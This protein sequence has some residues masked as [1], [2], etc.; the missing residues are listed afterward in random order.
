M[1]T[2][3]LFAC[4]LFL[5]L[6]ESCKKD[7]PGPPLQSSQEPL[8]KERAAVP[9]T[10][11][12]YNASVIEGRLAFKTKED[13][14]SLVTDPT[15]EKEAAFINWVDN[16]PDFVSHYRHHIDNRISDPIRDDFFGSILNQ[17]DI[18]QIG[19]HIFK[20]DMGKEKVFALGVVFESQLQYL[21]QENITNLK[22]K[23]FSTQEDVLEAIQLERWSIFCTEPYLPLQQHSKPFHATNVE[24][25]HLV[26]GIY[27]SLVSFIP[28]GSVNIYNFDAS[29]VYYKIRC[30]NTSGPYQIW[31]SMGN[32][33]FLSGGQKLTIYRGIHNFSKLH[34]TVRGRDN[35][36]NPVF[37]S[38]WVELR[39]NA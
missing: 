39:I 36:T 23:T 9:T 22:I 6:S 29:F 24:A 1:K 17:D 16:L 14:E 28:T 31:N 38:D 32:Y 5:G 20:V 10:T 37:T 25:N 12:E 21:L 18:V 7:L 11:N 19:G 33:D 26:A 3:I 30:D 2:P 27:F 34:F 13:Y 8:N 15:P 4:L 35:S